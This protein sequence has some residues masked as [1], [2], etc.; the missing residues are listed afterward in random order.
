MHA[1]FNLDPDLVEPSKHLIDDLDLD[2]IDL[3]DLAVA[4]EEQSGIALEEDELKSV[5]TVAD[6]VRVVHAAF[7]R[8]GASGQ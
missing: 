6:A 1:E 8:R 3:V 7:A 5:R 2:S 4:L